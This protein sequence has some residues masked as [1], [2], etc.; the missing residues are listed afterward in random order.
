MEAGPPAFYFLI[1]YLPRLT[2]GFCG[3]RH[4]SDEHH[5]PGSVRAPKRNQGSFRQ[6]KKGRGRPRPKKYLHG[7]VTIMVMIMVIPIALGAPAV[8]VFIPPAVP[9]VPAVLP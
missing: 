2:P 4:N 6:R 3:H 7:L 8:S 9:L 1:Q 5:E